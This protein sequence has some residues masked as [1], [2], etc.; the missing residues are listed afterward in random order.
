MSVTYRVVH[1]DGRTTDVH[2]TPVVGTADEDL[3]KRQANHQEAARLVI[4]MA[5]RLPSKGPFAM[6]VRAERVD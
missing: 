4:E 2:V 1:E 6:A 5:R 3:A